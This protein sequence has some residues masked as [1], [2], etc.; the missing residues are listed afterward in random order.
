MVI[1]SPLAGAA[2]RMNVPDVAVSTGISGKVYPLFV[3]YATAD[4]D[5]V[6]LNAARAVPLS[7]CRVNDFTSMGRNSKLPLHP[8]PEN[9]TPDHRYVTLCVPYPSRG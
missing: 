1:V 3:Q 4:P 9:G 8:E 2:H 5:A 6:P 7:M